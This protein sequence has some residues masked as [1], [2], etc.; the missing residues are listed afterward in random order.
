MCNNCI[1]SQA[2]VLTKYEAELNAV[3]RFLVWRVSKIDICL[4][5]IPVFSSQLTKKKATTT[6]KPPVKKMA[7]KVIWHS[8][9]QMSAIHLQLRHSVFTNELDNK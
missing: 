4:F 3:L 9:K 8:L 2:G 7:R 6:T 1:L 5:E